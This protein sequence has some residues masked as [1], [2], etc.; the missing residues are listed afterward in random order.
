MYTIEI[1]DD[2]KKI[3]IIGNM[4]HEDFMKVVDLVEYYNGYGLIF[5]KET[6]F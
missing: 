4:S 1:N 3:T 6:P 2:K 5:G